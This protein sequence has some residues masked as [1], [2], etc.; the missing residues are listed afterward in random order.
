MRV[1]F[2]Y[3]M[4]HV[5]DDKGSSSATLMFSFYVCVTQCYRAHYALSAA[6]LLR[7]TRSYRHWGCVTAKV[8]SNM[9]KELGEAEELDGFDEIPPEDQERLRK[10]WE[11][12]HVAE[13]DV[14]ET[15]DKS[16]MIPGY[17]D[18]DA[19]E[20][21]KKGGRKKVS[22]YDYRRGCPLSCM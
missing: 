14:P 1:Y 11:A 16:K 12:G 9:K 15:A 5:S 21:P 4:T 20:K 7:H 17:V 22:Y 18:P 6:T 3:S 19:P 2:V 13:E 10:A 8:L